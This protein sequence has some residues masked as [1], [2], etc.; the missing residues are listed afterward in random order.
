MYKL[1]EKDGN[2]NAILHTGKDFVK[3]FLSTKGV[4]SLIKSGKVSKGTE[5]EGYEICVNNEWYFE[6]TYSADKKKKEEKA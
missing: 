2:V 4:E 6:G 1:K 5:I 3:T